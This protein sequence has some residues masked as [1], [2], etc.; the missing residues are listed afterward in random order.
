MHAAIDSIA[1]VFEIT[2]IT[3][4]FNWQTTYWEGS[5]STTVNITDE[6]LY[7]IRVYFEQSLRKDNNVVEVY[8][9]NTNLRYLKL[10]FSSAGNCIMEQYLYFK[11]QT[12]FIYHESLGNNTGGLASIT[13]EKCF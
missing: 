11:P 3:S 6:G 4:I 2:S 9:N 13:I 10:D 12:L 1:S 5:G 7:R 8:K